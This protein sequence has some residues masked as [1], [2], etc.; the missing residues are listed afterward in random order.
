MKIVKCVKD[1]VIL[2]RRYIGRGDLVSDEDYRIKNINSDNPFINID[3][4]NTQY[5]V[6][7]KEKYH[8]GDEVSM[9][10][11]G[12]TIYGVVVDFSYVTKMYDVKFENKRE[13]DRVDE[14]KLRPAKAY[15]FINSEGVIHK[16]FFSANEKRDNFCRLTGNVFN[17]HEE[18]ENKL[19]KIFSGKI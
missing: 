14:K 9:S 11:D 3:L 1:V 17:T 2:G 5:F 19:N 12:K 10:Y 7:Y 13:T 15:F 8:K 16:T 4:S 6:P 18:A